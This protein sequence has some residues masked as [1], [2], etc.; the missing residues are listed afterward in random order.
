MRGRIFREEEGENGSNRQT[1]LTYA[2]W[3]QLYA[4]RDSAIGGELRINGDAHT[5]VGVLPP[6][7]HFLDPDVKLWLPIAFS[8]EEKSDDARHSNNWSMVGRLKP[9][10]TIQQAQQQLDALNARNMERFPHFKEILTN[11]GF[12]TVATSLQQDLVRGVRNTLFLLWG[13]VLFVLL[14]GAV[15]ITNLVLVRSSAR[16][17]ELAT[18]HALGARLSTLMRQLITETV[19]LTVLG[20]GLGLLAGYW[21]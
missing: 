19:L 9:G 11:A 20:G 16:M 4:G 13:G 14:I 7:F 1:I 8:A 15:N 21:G 2:L 3:Q 18:R 10:A 17:K 6:D 12:H 5:I